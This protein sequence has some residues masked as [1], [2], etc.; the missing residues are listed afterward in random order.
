M[1]ESME[2][3]PGESISA[4]E[5]ESEVSGNESLQEPEADPPQETHYPVFSLSP[6]GEIISDTPETAEDESSSPDADEP[7]SAIQPTPSP[8]A[9]Q[10]NE[11]DYLVIPGSNGNPTVIMQQPQQEPEEDPLD[12][13]AE[14]IDSIQSDI[15]YLAS[16]QASNYGYLGSQALDTFDRVVQQNSYRYYCAFRD[17]SDT[18]NGVLYLSDHI[19]RSGSTVTMEDALQVRVYRTYSGNT[20]YYYYSSAGAG[21][22]AVNL[23]GNLMYYTNTADNYPTLGGI[24]V[25]Y[26]YPSWVMPVLFVGLLAAFFAWRRR[27]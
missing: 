2:M 18:Y 5:S 20:Y 12:A 22:V 9:V 8:Y 26:R 15:A 25:P 4:E 19:S 27:S 1:D 24:S 6:D 17:G 14:Q 13:Y 23:S 11:G 10:V 16:V 7:P 21:D 3:V